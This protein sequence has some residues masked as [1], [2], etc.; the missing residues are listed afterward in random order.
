MTRGESAYA[1]MAARKMN[2]AQCVLT[3]FSEELGLERIQALKMA[4]GFGGGIGHT[5]Q[6]CGAVSGA[7]M[8]IGL[9]Q[10]LSSTNAQEVKDKTYALIK[11]FTG[12]FIKSNGSTSCTEL[13]GYDLSKPEQLTAAREK[14][15]FTTKCPQFVK[16]AVEIVEEMG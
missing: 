8:V 6:T 11:D 2:C 12:E 1:N 7:I 16:S 3:A 14:G 13:L 9:K 15:I 10:D 4:M 5:G